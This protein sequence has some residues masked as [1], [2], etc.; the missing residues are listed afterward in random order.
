M[1]RGKTETVT[2][3]VGEWQVANALVWGYTVSKGEC[4]VSVTADGKAI[5][6]GKGAPVDIPLT[7]GKEQKITF[8]FDNTS[9]AGP[10]Q[11]EITVYTADRTS[12]RYGGSGRGSSPQVVAADPAAAAGAD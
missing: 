7:P 6:G 3:V 4:N 1:D 8:V 12:A 11:A 2:C 9:G 5:S 10:A